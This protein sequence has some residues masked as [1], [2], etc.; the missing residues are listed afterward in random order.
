MGFMR[1]KWRQID[2]FTKIVSLV[3]FYSFFVDLL[4]DLMTF[5]SDDTSLLI[6]D[7]LFHVLFVYF[8]SF[9]LDVHQDR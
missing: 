6:S 4:D 8:S 3:C 9:Y 2:F 1:K 7:Y 5:D